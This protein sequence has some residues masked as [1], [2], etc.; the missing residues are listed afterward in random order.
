MARID[1]Q[2]L[3]LGTINFTEREITDPE[4]ENPCRSVAGRPQRVFHICE[5]VCHVWQSS[6]FI[7]D[8]DYGQEIEYRLGQRVMCFG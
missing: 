3:F 2:G 4:F 1:D 6:F 5:Q 7:L 8:D